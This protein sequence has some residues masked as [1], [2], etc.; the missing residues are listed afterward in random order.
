MQQGIST[1]LPH[2]KSWQRIQQLRNPQSCKHHKSA[3]DAELAALYYGC[4]LAV[5]SLNHPWQNGSLSTTNHCHNRQHH[6]SWPHY[7]HHDSKGIKIYGSTIQLVEMQASPMQFL[8]LWQRGILN[9]ADYA[10]KYQP[11]QHCQAVLPLWFFWFTSS[12][13]THQQYYLSNNQTT[14]K[15]WSWL[16]QPTSS[17]T[18]SNIGHL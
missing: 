3:L 5:P 7:W 11:A 14:T 8:Y 10:S 2:Q 18:N 17:P 6:S 15:G 9:Q 4:K 12:T 16:L 13:V 1:L